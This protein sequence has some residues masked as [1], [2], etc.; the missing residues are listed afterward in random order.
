MRL[1]SVASKGLTVRLSCL[2]ATGL[3]RSG[4][5]A[6]NKAVTGTPF[7]GFRGAKAPNDT[8]KKPGEG[9]GNG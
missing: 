8:Y 4:P 2:D 9:G 7:I 1:I 5:R 3:E 6:E